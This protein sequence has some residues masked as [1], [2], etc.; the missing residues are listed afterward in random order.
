M[1]HSAQLWHVRSTYG[2]HRGV[3]TYGIRSLCSQPYCLH[4]I[5]YWHNQQSPI[6]TL[7][8]YTHSILATT[9]VDDPSDR[10][11][12]TPAGTRYTVEA[13]DH[14]KTAATQAQLQSRYGEDNVVII[15]G[16]DGASW[17]ITSEDD[18]ITKDIE[19]L[20]SVRL[21]R[22]VKIVVN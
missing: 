6:I 3:R 18:D 22:R 17:T 14:T 15:D 19:T 7:L 5:H 20:E 8:L 4:F 2:G 1:R 9:S 21:V 13:T 12:S 16:Y 10:L 11:V